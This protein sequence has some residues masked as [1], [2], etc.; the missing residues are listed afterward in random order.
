MANYLSLFKSKMKT[1]KT[2]LRGS[3]INHA[4]ASALAT[5]DVYDEQK[6]SEALARLGQSGTEPLICVYCEAP[7]TTI[8]H[9]NGLV[10]NSSYTGHGHV[11]GN[12][13]PCCNSCNQRKGK[14]PWRDWA[15]TVGTPP[16]Q[17]ARIADYESLAPPTVSQE[18]L[19]QL[20]PDLMEAYDRL[21]LL[22]RDMLKA[23]D[24]LAREI[25]RLE[26]QRLHRR[27]D[28]GSGEA[29]ED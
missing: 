25:Q 6:L 19:K 26:S 17:V 9:L 3:T 24:H 18:D 2:S 7:G 13:V 23:A 16:D 10:V 12:L 5:A 20:Y 14:T 4:F 28:G 1:Y 21:R 15:R 29:V 8:D 11:I 22:T 27:L